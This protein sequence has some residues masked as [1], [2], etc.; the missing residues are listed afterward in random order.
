MTVG[1]VPTREQ[2]FDPEAPAEAQ[3]LAR[4]P[5]IQWFIDVLAAI[6]GNA[7]DVAT[8]TATVTA[9]TATVAA[10]GTWTAIPYSAGNFTAN[11]GMV[12]TVGSGDVKRHAYQKDGKRLTLAAVLVTTNISGAPDTDLRVS[13]GGFTAAHPGATVGYAYDDAGAGVLCRA[14]VNAGDAYVTAQLSTPGTAWQA[15]ADL[16]DVA[17]TLTIEVA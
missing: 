12:W 7:D 8:L 5:W 3:A 1:P 6:N 16:T 2:L 11:G 10:I 4:R 9:L 15:S 13:L 14:F 17:F